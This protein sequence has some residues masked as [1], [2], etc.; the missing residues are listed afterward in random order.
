AGSRGLGGWYRLINAA[1]R[2]PL[3]PARVAARASE[4]MTQRALA[5]IFAPDEMPDGYAEHIGTSLS[6]RRAT[7]TAN[8]RQVNA[9]LTH[10]RDMA[11]RY[12]RLPMPLEIVH[13]TADTIVPIGIHAEHLVRQVQGANLTRIEGAGHMPH[14]TH[15]DMLIAAIHRAFARARGR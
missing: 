8:A 15:P 10:V 14:H 1:P 6:L 5:S 2:R 12:P 11:P 3:L 4:G 9:L 7:L 13:G